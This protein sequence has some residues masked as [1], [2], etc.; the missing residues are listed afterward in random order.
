MRFPFLLDQSFLSQRFLRRSSTILAL[1][2]VMQTAWAQPKFRILQTVPGGLFSGLTFDAKGNLYG[3]TG[4]GGEHN[5]GSIFELSPG[6]KKWRGVYF[7]GFIP[8]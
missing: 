3:V 6:A 1:A 4:G 2:V 7:L 8:G 5:D